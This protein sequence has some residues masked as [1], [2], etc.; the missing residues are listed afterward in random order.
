MAKPNRRSNPPQQQPRQNTVVAEASFEGPI[1]PPALLQQY[2]QVITGAAER[3]LRMAEEQGRHRM[4]LETDAL[5]SNIKTQQMQ[6][7]TNHM[8]VRNVTI[9]DTLGQVFGLIVSAGCIIGGIWLVMQSH[10]VAGTALFSIPIAGIIK[11]FMIKP[12]K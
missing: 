11:A 4:Q 3:I 9:S 1:P 2:D 7:K 12:G 10:E 5:A 8:Q 6:A